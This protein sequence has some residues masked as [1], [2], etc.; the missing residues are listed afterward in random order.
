MNGWDIAVNVSNLISRLP[1]ERLLSRGP[2]KELDA[3]EQRLK[4]KGLLAPKMVGNPTGLTK[5]SAPSQNPPKIAPQSPSARENPSSPKKTKELEF[6][7]G[8]ASQ[9]QVKN[10]QIMEI[11]GKIDVIDRHLAN[12]CRIPPGQLPCDC[13][14]NHLSGLREVCLESIK[15]MPERES[16]LRKLADWSLDLVMKSPDMLTLPFSDD[17]FTKKQTELRRLR[18]QLTGATKPALAE[19]FESELGEHFEEA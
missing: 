9:E 1:I 16:D 15:I 14:P 19:R 8:F 10:Y 3:F 5:T 18:K 17:E 6:P 12:K 13:C 4:E 11:L 7:P 2:V